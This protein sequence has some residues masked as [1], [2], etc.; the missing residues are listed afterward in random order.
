VWVGVLLRAFACLC[1]LRYWFYVRCLVGLVE[2]LDWL[3]LDLGVVGT[4]FWGL[5]GMC[6]V[7]LYVWCCVTGG[8]VW[9]VLFGVGVWVGFW[10]WGRGV[11]C[12]FLR[13][14]VLISYL[15]GWLMVTFVV[16]YYC[17]T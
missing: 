10:G 11:T 8:V 9:D 5:D 15:V 4:L 2:L 1:L 17:Y 14:G 3:L 6:L 16:Y 7:C 12:V 13:V